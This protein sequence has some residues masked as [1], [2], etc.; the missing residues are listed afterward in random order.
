MQKEELIGLA[1]SYERSAD[2]LH[3]AIR[4]IVQEAGGFINTS[5]N[6]G[7][8]KNLEALVYDKRQRG[9]SKVP[10]DAIRVGS[11]GNVE[12]YLGSETGIYTDKYLRGPLSAEHWHPLRG[13]EI[14]FLQTVLSIARSVEDYLPGTNPD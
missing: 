2:T 13:S 12:V 10:I 1:R 6:M 14:L 4:E 3:D 5:N 9:Y 11:E 7:R 8:Q